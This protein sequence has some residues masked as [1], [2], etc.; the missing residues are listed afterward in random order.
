MLYNTHKS[1][2][3]PQEL[4]VSMALYGLGDCPGALAGQIHAGVAVRR[5]ALMWQQRALMWGTG[6]WDSSWYLTNDHCRTSGHL[7]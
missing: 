5:G 4:S 6:V 2:T 7:L 3:V 1:S